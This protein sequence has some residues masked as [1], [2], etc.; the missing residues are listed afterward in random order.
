MNKEKWSPN[1]VARLI[2]KREELTKEKQN[3]ERID[4]YLTHRDTIDSIIQTIESDPFTEVKLYGHRTPTEILRYLQYLGFQITIYNR[5]GAPVE[6]TITLP[7]NSDS[8][9]SD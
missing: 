6:V 2:N 4:W 9:S 5:P 3:K 8:S 7:S 1:I